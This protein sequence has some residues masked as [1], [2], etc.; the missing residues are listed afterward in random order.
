MGPNYLLLDVRFFCASAPKRVSRRFAPL[1]SA[2]PSTLAGRRSPALQELTLLEIRFL[3]F[4][5]KDHAHKVTSLE[6][7][8]EA[9]G[10][11]HVRSP[12][13]LIPPFCL[14]LSFVFLL[15]QLCVS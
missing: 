13:S 12:L 4:V 10:L 5:H 11:A 15:T 14:T 6:K 1:H 8:K 2:C 9:T 7:G 3:L